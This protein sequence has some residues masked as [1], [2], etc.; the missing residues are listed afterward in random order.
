MDRFF[1]YRMQNI[2]EIYKKLQKFQGKM[3]H[4][5]PRQLLLEAKQAGFSDAQIGRTM[6]NSEKIIRTQRKKLEILPFVKQIDTVAAEWP[7]ATNYL[8]LTYNG[9]EHDV[10]PNTVSIFFE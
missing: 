7:A 5:V 1:L 6:K 2:I 8:Y 3:A 4:E 9:I 10:E